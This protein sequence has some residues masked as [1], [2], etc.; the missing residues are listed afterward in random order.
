MVM[1]WTL[2]ES[3]SPIFSALFTWNINYFWTKAYCRTLPNLFTRH[4]VNFYY[5]YDKGRPFSYPGIQLA[6]LLTL[7]QSFMLNF[8]WREIIMAFLELLQLM[9]NL[10]TSYSFR[11]AGDTKQRQFYIAGRQCLQVLP[12]NLWMDCKVIHG[13]QAVICGTCSIFLSDSKDKK[14]VILY[15]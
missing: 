11:Y 1:L 2:K 8:L 10:G 9:V 3:P 4:S 15:S 13:W 7:L 12:Y 5:T 14:K 6:V